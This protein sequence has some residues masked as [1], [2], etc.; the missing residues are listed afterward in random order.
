MTSARF[1]AVGA[2]LAL[3][4]LAAAAPQDPAPTPVQDPPKP[5]IEQP[6]DGSARSP[7]PA[8]LVAGEIPATATEAAR[9]A[10][11]ALCAATG[12]APAMDAVT[13]FDLSFE[14]RAWQTDGQGE[15]SF[16]N[17]RLRFLAPKFVD[18]TLESGRRRLRGPRGD[19]IVD[20]KGHAL[21]LQGVELA[22]DRRELDQIV[23]VA[24][25]F[26]NLINARNLR[27]RAIELLDA[28][29]FALPQSVA[30]RSRDRTWL[31]I[32][33]P[34]FAI[35]RSDGSA[36]EREVRAWIAL[37]PKTRLPSLA[38]VAEDDRGTLVVESA[39][40][41]ELGNFKAIDGLNTPMSVRTFSPDTS[42]T[43][44]TFH[45]QQSLQ[46]WLTKGTLRPKLTPTDF[47]PPK[48]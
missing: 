37:D 20:A 16:K 33:S 15:K 7:T 47:E 46:L 25:T 17:G 21:R 19:W 10:W 45:E 2:L 26:A 6:A 43:P 31:S 24:R 9:A 30:E 42:R 5:P 27:L 8:P 22:Q 36:S 1:R 14:A 23:H 12:T 41:V 34:D 11:L 3:A 40:L 18:S 35:A 4:A 38:V 29:P 13:A 28:P 44:W 48:D 39:L 32:V